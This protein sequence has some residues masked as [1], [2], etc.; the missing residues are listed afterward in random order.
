MFLSEF[1]SSLIFSIRL[2]TLIFLFLPLA[3]ACW[4]ARRAE[5]FQGWVWGVVLDHLDL[6]LQEFVDR[7]IRHLGRLGVIREHRRTLL[8]N[9]LLRVVVLDV[10]SLL[11]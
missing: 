9:D 6:F 3:V 7:C 10:A 1:F 8:Q 2:S 11:R 4:V 5:A